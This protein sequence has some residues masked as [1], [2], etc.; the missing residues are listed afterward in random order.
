MVR[1]RH[2]VLLFLIGVLAVMCINFGCTEGDDTTPTSVSFINAIQTGGA[3]N[4]ADSTALTLTF[5]ID[6]TTLTAD[7]I[8]V[9]GATK[10]VLSGTGTTRSLAIS[11]ITVANGETVSVAI[12]NPSGY[13][14]SGS[15]QTAVVYKFLP[16]I[17]AAYQGGIIAYIL[18]PGDAGYDANIIH[19]L[20]VSTNLLGTCQ[21]AL[22][23]YQAVNVPG[24]TST[25]YSAG[26]VNTSNIIAQNGSSTTFAAGLAH[27]EDSG[28]FS[29][30]F[31]PSLDELNKVYENRA[32][33]NGINSTV[34]YWSSSE[35]WILN[36]NRVWVLDFVTGNMPSS[37]K[38]FTG[39]SV[40]AVRYF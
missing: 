40:M 34:M 1:K 30:W 33:I 10:G 24:S 32:S 2:M 25:N 11:D 29:D 35:D 3:S 7:D 4:S 18:Q 16:V 38:N 6:P 19:G 15:P 23:T 17:G 12:T 31:L 36:N 27:S 14:I 39:H 28:G 26:V 20:I 9:T 37:Y 5:D 13:T 8:T 21:W 22:S